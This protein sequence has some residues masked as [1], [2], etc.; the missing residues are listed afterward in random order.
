[1][2]KLLLLIA[3][4]AMSVTTASAQIEKTEATLAKERNAIGIRLGYG[5]DLSYQRYLQDNNRIEANLGLNF[6]DGN[7]FTANAIYQWLFGLQVDNVG[8]NWYAGAGAGVGVWEDNFGLAVVGQIG[9]EYKFKAPIS[10][11]LDWRPAL[12]LVPGFGFGWDSFA[13]GVRYRF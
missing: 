8:F 5:L 2:K 10:L 11:S 9:I 12:N 3:V 6:G 13:V 1:M 7:G 4:V